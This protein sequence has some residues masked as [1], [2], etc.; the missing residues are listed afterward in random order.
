MYNLYCPLYFLIKF[1]YLISCILIIFR[2]WSSLFLVFSFSQNIYWL[3]HS[4]SDCRFSLFL[5]LYFSVFNYKTL[6]YF[7]LTLCSCVQ[8][9]T[10]INPQ[11]Y[12]DNITE[13][14]NYFHQFCVCNNNMADPQICEPS[15]TLALQALRNPN[16]G[17]VPCSTV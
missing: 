10:H 17:Y 11:F 8:L 14:S 12:M 16:S 9:F 2:I 6:R 15:P 13:V 3:F 5:P 7:I 4:L 1:F